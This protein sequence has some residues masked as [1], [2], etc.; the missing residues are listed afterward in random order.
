MLNNSFIF[1]GSQLGQHHLILETFLEILG[2]ELP[3]LR[4]ITVTSVEEGI[5]ELSGIDP[6]YTSSNTKAQRIH[7]RWKG[8]LAT[9]LPH[10][11]KEFRGQRRFFVVKENVFLVCKKINSRHAFPGNV[12][13]NASNRIRNQLSLFGE[14]YVF[15]CYT[16]NKSG[17][18]IQDVLVKYIIGNEVIWEYDLLNQ[19]NIGGLQL[20]IT[21][22]ATTGDD[23]DLRVIPKRKNDQNRREMR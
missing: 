16:L 13:T 17:D 23:D 4:D 15:L 9:R 1:K 8:N 11:F 12:P 2:D 18:G 20:G 3:I 14:H 19:S 5:V 10:L 21:P 7:D 6:L 22:I